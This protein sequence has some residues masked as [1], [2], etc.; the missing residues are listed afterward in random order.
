MLASQILE[1]FYKQ[2]S[3]YKNIGYS[4]GNVQYRE[5]LHPLLVF[6]QYIIDTL[7]VRGEKRIAIVLPDDDC[8][9]LPLI[10]AKCF[11]NIQDESGFAGSVLDEIE[12]GQMLR[13]GDAVVKYLGRVGD[14]KIKYSV[15][16]N[17]KTQTTF[18][19]SISEYHNF[20]EKCN[21]AVSSL[22]RYFQA[23]KK[24][25]EMIKSGHNNELNAIKLKRTTIKKTTLLLSAKNDFHDFMHQVK[26]DNRDVNDI[27][28]YGEIDLNGDSG[29][30]LYNKGKLDC[31]P[32]ITVSAKLDEINDALHI[33]SIAK[34]VGDIFSTVDKFDELVDNGEALKGC[35]RKGI[36]FIAFVPEHAFEK[37]TL[38]KNLGFKMWHWKPA[39]LKS[40]VFLRDGV[41]DRQE[42]I[43]GAIS[44]K[45][46]SA[47][48]AEYDFVS[49]A[50]NK[51]KSGLHLIKDI[52]LKTNDCD[53]T[54]KQLVRRLWGLQ[55]EMVAAGYIDNYVATNIREEFE[56][57][58]SSWAEQKTFYIQQSFYD[59]VECVLNL[60]REWLLIRETSKQIK[61]KE[62]LSSLPDEYETATVLVS[63]RYM[64][65]DKLQK[66]ASEI[67]PKKQL[68]V[69]KLS[70]FYIMQDRS[71][72]ETDV[73]IVPTFDKNEYIR[74]KQTYCYKKLTYI[75]YDFENR[76]RIGLV[77]KIDECMPY[78]EIKERAVEIGLSENDLSPKTLDDT[79]ADAMEPE[80]REISDYNFASSVIRSTLKTQE[81]TRDSADAIECVPILLSGDKIAYFYPTHD[82]IDVTALTAFD[83]QR[84]I[85]KD[86]IRLRKGD[87]IL[88]RQSDRDII[89]EKADILMTHDGK[90]DL[91]ELADIWCS[92]LQCYANGKSIT[93][94]HNAINNAGVECTFQQVRYWISGETILPRDKNVLVAI[95]KICGEEPGFREMI[96]A[97]SENIDRI[98]ECGRQVQSYHQKA[99]VWVTKELRN[100]A[101]EI[102]KIA[103]LPNPCGSI[104]GIGDVSIYT[105]EDVLDKMVIERNKLN[106]VEFLY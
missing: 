1:Q 96:A 63:D 69:S 8:E 16:R 83:A 14:D 19:C 30:A 89:K 86:A 11:A 67:V 88:I 32:A 68:C 55:N 80:D 78:D 42:R 101:T 84:P 25:E 10:L 37:F 4:L 90:S 97:Y 24:I 61:L 33:D 12:P 20:F 31:L 46:S 27:I 21:G 93:Q 53:T 65:V 82:V 35:L 100:K 76:W 13:L 22:P 71:W 3:T 75:L 94:V 60:F 99:G 17:E 43:F 87:K 66:W 50:D 57:I 64:Y 106:R 91:R 40:E 9:I 7:V 72:H 44:K 104:E 56:K 98:F 81:S 54:L 105:V 52:S 15:G 29:F 39:T 95:G 59:A 45:I 41:S 103:S 2:H 73:L 28:T 85:K 79:D 48:L 51:L 74:I 5:H 36:P 23:R 92:L 47:A 58:E 6:T 49:C 18:T 70:D 38:I 26:I 34:K 77:K 102:R 62:Y